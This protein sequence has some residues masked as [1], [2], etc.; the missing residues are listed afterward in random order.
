VAEL[1]VLT[2]GLRVRRS[3][4]E[5]VTVALWEGGMVTHGNY[6]LMLTHT[7]PGVLI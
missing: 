4:G 2:A 3:D 1:F 5:V 7:H 6:G